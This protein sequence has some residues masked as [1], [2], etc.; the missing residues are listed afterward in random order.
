VGTPVFLDKDQIYNIHEQQIAFFGGEQG[1]RDDGLLESAVSAPINYFCYAGKRNLFDLAACYA[2]HLA[3]NHPFVDGNK[4]AGYAAAIAFLKANG[5]PLEGDQNR[6][7]DAMLKLTVS[8]ITQ[9]EF[10]TILS[11]EAGLGS[12]ILANLYMDLEP[13]WSP[14]LNC[15]THYLPMSL[16]SGE[17]VSVLHYWY[18]LQYFNPL[19]IQSRPQTH[20]FSDQFPLSS[21]RSLR[22]INRSISEN[23]ASGLRA[24]RNRL[25]NRQ[26]ELFFAWM[27]CEKSGGFHKSPVNMGRNGAFFQ[28]GGFQKNDVKSTIDYNLSSGVW[29]TRRH[30]HQK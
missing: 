3:K 20:P 27:I 11:Q 14:I 25:E 24:A 1:I 9:S 10:S 12:Q 5:I 8:E 7:I 15:T 18:F 30:E 23:P 22:S 4:R 16:S 28:K 17:P 26:S 2:F 19:E 29:E 21:L 13:L 6:L